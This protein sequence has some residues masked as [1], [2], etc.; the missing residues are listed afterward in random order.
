MGAID[1]GFLETGV[2]AGVAPEGEQ[3]FGGAF[4]NG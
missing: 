3:A 2:H 4:G 1:R